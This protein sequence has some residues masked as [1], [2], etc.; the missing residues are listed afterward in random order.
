MGNENGQNK[1]VGTRIATFINAE[2]QAERKQASEEEGRTLRAAAGRLDQLL[3]EIK[4]Q[5][6]DKQVTDDDLKALRAAA[7]KLSQLLG[8]GKGPGESK[9]HLGKKHAAE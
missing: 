9:A 7:V 8:D 3:T 4:D 6:R 2:G 5:P 1:D